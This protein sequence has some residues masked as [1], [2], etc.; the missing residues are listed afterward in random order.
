MKGVPRTLYERRS[1]NR[2]LPLVRAVV[3]DV[4]GDFRTLRRLG[5]AQRSLA[6]HG[7]GSDETVTRLARLDREVQDLSARLESYLR[8]IEDL[9]LEM[10]DIETGA[11]DFPTVMRG[12]PAFLCWRLGEEE[13]RWWHRATAGFAD[14]QPIPEDLPVQ[15]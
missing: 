10:R 12:E 11:V 8:E 15:G 3:R 5:R 6:S 4:V 14:R 9:G 2:A 1:A 13:V 7:D